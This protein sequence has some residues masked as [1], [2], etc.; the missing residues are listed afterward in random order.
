MRYSKLL[1]KVDVPEG[2]S[3]DWDVIRFEV[4]P[5]GADNDRLRAQ[6]AAYQG[7]RV[8]SVPAGV[9]TQLKCGSTIV[10]SDTPGEMVDHI[11][12]VIRATGRVLIAGLGIGM[13]L[14]A[15]LD[16]PGVTHVTVVELSEDV[17]KLVGPHYEERYGDRLLIRQGNIMSWCPPRGTNLQPYDAAWFDIWDNKC[18]DNLPEMTTLSRRFSRWA[19]WKGHWGRDDC[20]F[21]AR[22][23]R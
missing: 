11:D 10:M 17:I 14:Q 20:R 19:K 6:I 12:P 9:Y 5:E 8:M 22:R 1:R 2:T 23:H 4:T 18:G 13:V 16:K 15:V 7:R 3:G 21:Y